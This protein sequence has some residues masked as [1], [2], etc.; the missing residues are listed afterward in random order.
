MCFFLSHFFPSEHKAYYIKQNKY[1]KKT[2]THTLHARARERERENIMAKRL[3]NFESS[4]IRAP[5]TEEKR[6]EV[7][8]YSCATRSMN[9]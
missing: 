6:T 8:S 4:S 2:H 9:Q 7:L 3:C 1:R 5:N